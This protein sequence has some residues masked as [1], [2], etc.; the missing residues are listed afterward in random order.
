MLQAAPLGDRIG[1]FAYANSPHDA[2]ASYG[3]RG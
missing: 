3:I 2:V 1:E